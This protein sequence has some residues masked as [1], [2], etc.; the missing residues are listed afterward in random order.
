MVDRPGDGEGRGL[1]AGGEERDHDLPQLAVVEPAA[2]LIASLDQGAQQ[3]AALRCAPGVDD[4]S[5]DRV[6]TTDGPME[7]RV[8]GSPG[9]ERDRQ[10][11]RKEALEPVGQDPEGVGRLLG[12]R[13]QVRADCRFV[14]RQSVTTHS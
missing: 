2:G 4:L 5:R 8:S 10:P 7:A 12:P 13:V 1:V 6:E 11:P 3:V 14:V 9:G